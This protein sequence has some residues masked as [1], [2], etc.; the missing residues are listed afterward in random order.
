MSVLWIALVL[1]LPIVGSI[2]YLLGR[3]PGRE[4]AGQQSRAEADR[5]RTAAAR[6]FDSTGMGP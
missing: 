2:I 1:V 6:P 4:E 5:R 3:T